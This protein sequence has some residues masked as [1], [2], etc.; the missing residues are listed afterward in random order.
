VGGRGWSLGR[1]RRWLRGL[2]GGRGGPPRTRTSRR[3]ASGSSALGERCRE[4]AEPE[5]PVTTNTAQSE[6]LRQQAARP[7]HVSGGR[8]RWS[9]KESTR[10]PYSGQHGAAE[11]QAHQSPGA[12]LDEERACLPWSNQHSC[13][14]QWFRKSPRTPG[15]ATL[16]PPC[17]SLVGPPLREVYNGVQHQR[18]LGVQLRAAR[19]L[20]PLGD[21]DDRRASQPPRGSL[22]R[23]ARLALLLWRPGEGDHILEPPGPEINNQACIFVVITSGSVAGDWHNTRHTGQL[24][25]SRTPERVLPSQRRCAWESATRTRRDGH[26]GH[27]VDRLH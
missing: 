22:C 15:P 18:G 26:V 9:A 16:T 1:R 12:H 14:R 4:K 17:V 19:H 23:V 21:E 7:W 24:R 20:R 13:W 5:Q 11:D 10:R 6:R 25:C 2:I 3:C 8:S 27:Y